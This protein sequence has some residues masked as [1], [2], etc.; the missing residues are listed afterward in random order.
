MHA[1]DEYVSIDDYIT[2]IKVVAFSIC[3]WCDA[4]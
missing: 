1:T 4:K 2:A 3:D